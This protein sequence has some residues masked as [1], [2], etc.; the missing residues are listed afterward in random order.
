MWPL[1]VA[2][3]STP[4]LQLPSHLCLQVFCQDSKFDLDFTGFCGAGWCGETVLVLLLSL[5][6]QFSPQCSLGGLHRDG[7]ALS[8]FLPCL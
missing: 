4:R 5:V 8:M 3:P 7:W 6:Y 1:L 2:H